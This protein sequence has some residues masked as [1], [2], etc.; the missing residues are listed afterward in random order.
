V[1]LVAYRR[2]QDD[3]S[4]KASTNR[5]RIEGIRVILKGVLIFYA[6]KL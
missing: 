5:F 2:K 3:G 6:Q 4:E 1:G